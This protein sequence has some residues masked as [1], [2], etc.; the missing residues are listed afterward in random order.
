MMTV[1]IPVPSANAVTNLLGVLGLVAVVVA[2][3]GLAGVWWAL[4][5]AGVVAVTLSV[6]AQTLGDRVA[7]PVAA[8]DAPTRELKRVS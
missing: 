4:L 2:I 3:G 7:A 8:A 1:R 5:A 6:L